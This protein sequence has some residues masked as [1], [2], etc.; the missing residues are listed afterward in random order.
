MWFWY[1][2]LNQGVGD[3]L[4]FIRLL[5][6]RLVDC[7]WQEWNTHIQNSKRFEM[8][9]QFNSFHAVPAYLSV[10]MEKHLKFIMTR[11]RFGVSDIAS[12]HL[13]YRQYSD[14]DLLCPLCNNAEEN[15]VHFV[16]CCP[17]LNDLRVSLLP[18]KYY[19]QP[20]EFKLVL[21]MASRHEEIVKHLAVYLYKAF[22]IRSIAY[23]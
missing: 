21:L 13:R 1:V 22:K 23:S 11:F 2:W 20:S 17:A 15:E 3:T 8:F 14:R 19:N 7:R 5:R 12:H 10:K 4:M 6:S 18:R 9:R 16:F